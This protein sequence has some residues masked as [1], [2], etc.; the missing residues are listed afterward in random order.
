[1]H[2][3]GQAAHVLVKSILTCLS[4]VVA[5]PAVQ[6]QGAWV[7][8]W[9]LKIRFCERLGQDF[10]SDP[11]LAMPRSGCYCGPM[12]ESVRAGIRGC[13]VWAVGW[14]QGVEVMRKGGA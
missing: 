2:S 3:Q 5:E 7:C 6:L 10:A 4:A 14:R 1:M 11:M 13:G 12:T 9:G 8:S